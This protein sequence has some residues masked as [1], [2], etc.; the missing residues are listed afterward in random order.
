MDHKCDRQTDRRY[1]S[2]GRAVWDALIRV[3]ILRFSV[4]HGVASGEGVKP[5]LR[6]F[7][8]LSSVDGILHASGYLI[9]SECNSRTLCPQ[10][11]KTWRY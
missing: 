5:L 8:V 4:L 3:V 7:S 6:K 1:D 10:T 2:K 9:H 11:E